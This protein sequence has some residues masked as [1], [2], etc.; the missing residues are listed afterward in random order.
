M[1]APTRLEAAQAKATSRLDAALA[2]RRPCRPVKVRVLGVDHDAV[3]TLVGSARLLGVEAAVA[4]RMAERGI[5]QNVL[6]E[7]RFELEVA[8][9]TLAI[10]VLVSEDNPVPFGSEAAWGE[11]APEVISD[12]WAT[13]GGL[14]A[15]EDPSTDDDDIPAEEAAAIRDAVSKKNER[16]LRYFGARRLA[17]YLLT[18]VGQPASSSTERSSPGVSSSDT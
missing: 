8:W 15:A 1:A 5:A 17:R 4:R 7:G 18:T 11:L 13:F 6:N 16:L 3:M 9:C 2:G 12:L 14:R 10:A